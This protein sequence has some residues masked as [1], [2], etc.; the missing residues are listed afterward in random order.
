MTITNATG[1]RQANRAGRGSLRDL[2]NLLKDLVDD[3]TTEMSVATLTVT[4]TA[5]LGDA[6]S[7]KVGFFGTT[8]AAQQT[9][10][11]VSTSGTL[12]DVRSTLQDLQAALNTYGLVASS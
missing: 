8:A 12:G 2:E 10:T 4:G 6:A 1:Q 7:D 3:V 9:V 5:N 11:L